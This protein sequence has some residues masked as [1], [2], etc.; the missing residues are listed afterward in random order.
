LVFIILLVAIGYRADQ[1]QA[2]FKSNFH[3]LSTKVAELQSKRIEL[4]QFF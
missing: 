1:V 3:T 2:C 4:S